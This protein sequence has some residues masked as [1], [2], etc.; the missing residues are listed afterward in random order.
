[1]R[2]ILTGDLGSRSTPR[3]SFQLDTKLLLAT[4][5]VL[6]LPGPTARSSSR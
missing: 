6:F 2:I 4:L 3:R 5:L 1:M